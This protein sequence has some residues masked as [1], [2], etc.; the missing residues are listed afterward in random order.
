MASTLHHL[1]NSNPHT[2]EV[3]TGAFNFEFDFESRCRGGFIE[4]NITDFTY[5]KM[6][7]K[8]GSNGVVFTVSRLLLSSVSLILHVPL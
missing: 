4:D 6:D 5:N 2:F 7:V 8:F 3:R 1:S